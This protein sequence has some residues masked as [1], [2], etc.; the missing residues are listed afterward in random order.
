MRVPVA[1]SGLRIWLAVCVLCLGVAM[2]SGSE[3][4]VKPRFM[5]AFDTS[6]SMS[7]D[8]SSNDTGNGSGIGRPAVAGDPANLVRNGVFYGCGT[9]AGSDNDG[10]C[11]PDDSRIFIAKEAVRTGK[12]ILQIARERRVLSEAQLDAL[13]APE[14]MTS[15]DPE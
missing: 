4:Q 3:A 7:W 9:L 15:P 12:S 2:P 6:G 1:C 8:I 5:I 14:R 13:L 11:F 10:D